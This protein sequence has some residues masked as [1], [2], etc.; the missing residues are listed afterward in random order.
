MRRV[1][2]LLTSFFFLELNSIFC[3]L[4]FSPAFLAI[5]IMYFLYIFYQ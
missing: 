2:E 1:V 4:F 3:I 5:E